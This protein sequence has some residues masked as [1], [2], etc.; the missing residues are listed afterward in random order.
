[1]KIQL[2][3]TEKNKLDE[4]C[5]CFKKYVDTYIVVEPKSEKKKLFQTDF[6]SG[7]DI[8]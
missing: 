3:Q 4:I 7:Y 8:S 5:G 6:E 2:T 1:M